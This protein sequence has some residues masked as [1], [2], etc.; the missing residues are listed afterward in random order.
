M[1][2]LVLERVGHSGT[3]PYPFTLSLT[4]VRGPYMHSL[5][6]LLLASHTSF[7]LTQGSTNFSQTT[8]GGKGGCATYPIFPKAAYI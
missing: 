6:T 4:D 1:L 7:N 2:L 5:H 8:G 3:E